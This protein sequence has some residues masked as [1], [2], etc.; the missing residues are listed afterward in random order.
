MIPMIG[1]VSQP[2][3]NK[4]DNILF[5]LFFSSGKVTLTVWREITLLMLKCRRKVSPSAKAEALCYQ[6]SKEKEMMLNIR[7]SVDGCVDCFV[8]CSSEC[9]STWHM[10]SM[11]QVL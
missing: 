11:V 2:T 3:F 10:F 4:V 9:P 6:N 8:P 5:N 1:W 7:I